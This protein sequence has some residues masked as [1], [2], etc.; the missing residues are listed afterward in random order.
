M[1][2]QTHDTITS[3]P[4]MY[5]SYLHKIPEN[6]LNFSAYATESWKNMHADKNIKSKDFTSDWK[7]LN[8]ELRDYNYVCSVADEYVANRK[9][10]DTIVAGFEKKKLA[11]LEKEDFKNPFAQGDDDLY[12][13]LQ[14]SN[15]YFVNGYLSV[16]VI[17]HN[18]FKEKRE[19]YVYTDY[20][21]ERP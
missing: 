6:Y 12:D 13:D 21:E 10:W 4:L 7:E 20:Y 18:D 9:R 3:F 8:K 2:Y 11:W 19:R 5:F 15:L 17:N 14:M 1:V 16:F